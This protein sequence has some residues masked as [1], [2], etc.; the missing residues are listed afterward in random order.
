MTSSAHDPELQ[1][2]LDSAE[3]IMRGDRRDWAAN[4]HDAFLFGLFRG[5]DCEIDH[6]HDDQCPD[7]ATVAQAHGWDEDFVARLRRLRGGV[8]AVTSGERPS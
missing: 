8:R 3:R 6:T 4:R 5:W 2:A 7:M 1:E